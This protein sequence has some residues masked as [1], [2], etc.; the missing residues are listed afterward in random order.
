MEKE[1]LFIT[2]MGRDRKGIVARISNF[3]Y[4]RDIN[5]EDISQK[6]MEGYFVMAML[7]DI[8]DTKSKLEKIVSGLEKV[9]EEM[10][11]KIQVQHEDIF[12]A[13]HRV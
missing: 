9:G 2:V 4:K 12:K 13:M 7:V 11:L 3:L 6:I 8:R 1:L 5:I 10:Q